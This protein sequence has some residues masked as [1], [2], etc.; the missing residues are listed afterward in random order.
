MGVHLFGKNDPLHFGSLGNALIS[1]FQVITLENWASIYAIQKYG[2]AAQGYEGMEHLIVESQ[3]QPAVA[4]LYFV[5]FILLGTM[6]MLNLFIGVIMNSM[7]ESNAELEGEK[8]AA[9]PQPPGSVSIGNR[10]VLEQLRLLERQL[11]EMKHGI[12]A[13]RIK[14]DERPEPAPALGLDRRG[15]NVQLLK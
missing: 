11:Q 3:A 15:E 2:A 13:L 5:S 7:T 9:H 6:I 12:D 1:L 4:T 8:N 10:P 14:L